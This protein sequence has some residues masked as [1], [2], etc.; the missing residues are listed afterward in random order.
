MAGPVSSRNSDLI[1][2]KRSF[3][4]VLTVDDGEILAIG[5]LLYSSGVAFYLNKQL[6]YARAIWHGHVVAGAGVHWAAVLLGVVLTA[7]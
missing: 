1:L 7:R 4:T 3:E 5:G 2:N 6:R